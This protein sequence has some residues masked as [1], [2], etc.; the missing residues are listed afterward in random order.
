MM[1]LLVAAVLPELRSAIARPCS[2]P[3]QDCQAQHATRTPGVHMGLRG[4]PKRPAAVD[5]DRPQ[6]P[7]GPARAYRYRL[8]LRR[9]Y[10]Y[11]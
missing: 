3:P 6:G 5:R 1:Q 2:Q 10:R 11:R 4:L 8:A 9:P 7:G